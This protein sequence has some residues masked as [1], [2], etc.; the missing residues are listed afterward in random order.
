MT[1]SA[2]ANDQPRI[3]EHTINLVRISGTQK[4]QHT[5]LES[6]E[7]FFFTANIIIEFKVD[8]DEQALAQ[9]KAKKYYEKYQHQGQEIYIVGISFDSEQKNIS[10]YQWQKI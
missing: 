3:G 10:D 4:R 9:I 6:H 2:S 1:A 7:D 8:K 5:T